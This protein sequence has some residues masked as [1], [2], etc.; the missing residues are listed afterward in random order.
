MRMM[1]GD[2]QSK[3]DLGKHKLLALPVKV[4]EQILL[5]AVSTH[6]GQERLGTAS[7]DLSGVSH[8]QQTRSP[9]G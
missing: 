8:G 5:A 7:R 9:S 4:M 6:D 3:E 1:M 2:T